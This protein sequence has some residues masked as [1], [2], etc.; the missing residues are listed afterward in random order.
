ME[1][2]E[3]H[4]SLA[5]YVQKYLLVQSFFWRHK[6]ESARIRGNKWNEMHLSDKQRLRFNKEL[7]VYKGQE[8]SLLQIQ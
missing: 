6:S 8:K 5:G 2:F 3:W 7:V 4:T 1:S